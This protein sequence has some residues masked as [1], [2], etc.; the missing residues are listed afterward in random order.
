MNSRIEQIIEEIEEY[1]EN[2]RLQPLSTTKIIVNKEHMNELVNE[3]RLKVP[4]E[5]DRYKKIIANRDAILEDAQA[6]A[7][8]LLEE[9]KIQ[10]NELVSEH[11]I[12]QQA[13]AQA[14][15]VL[16][17]ATEQAQEILDK[18]TID[19]ND[20]RIGA[21]EYTDDLMS[22]AEMTLHEA[23]ESYTSRQDRFLDTLRENYERVRRNRSELTIPSRQQ[24]P[25]VNQQTQQRPQPSL[26]QTVGEEPPAVTEEPED[27]FIEI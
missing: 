14:D 13:Y 18:A 12:M 25:V 19:A 6:K 8:K 20:I 10:S 27:D 2:C 16:T 23:L 17:K 5:I 7:D 21:L 3:L 9:T 15:S 4:D 26:M 24:A 1:I 11:E 22:D